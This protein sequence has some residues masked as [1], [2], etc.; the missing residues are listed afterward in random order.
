MVDRA[1]GFATNNSRPWSI[2]AA[3]PSARYGRC[4]TSLSAGKGGGK[5][6]KKKS[7]RTAQTT[8]GFGAPPPRLEEVLA[9]FKTRAPDDADARPCPCGSGEVYGACC[10]PLHRGDRPRATMTDVLRSRYVAFSWRNIGYVM[11]TT[12]ES[13]RDYRDDRVAWARD[14]DRGG[15]FDSFEFV[16]LSAGPEEINE[17]DGNE[18]FVEFEVTL[19]AKEDEDNP[20]AGQ[21]TLISERSRFLRN[22]K[23]GSWSYASGD[24][25][26]NVAGLEDTTLNA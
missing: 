22:P 18:G 2:A 20:V 21:E 9:A 3:P 24:V 1:V 11:D 17:D 12:H 8:K 25:R 26:S 4:R 14:L 6:K 10:G 13:C 15:M 16:R 19:R 5:N 23:D 7:K